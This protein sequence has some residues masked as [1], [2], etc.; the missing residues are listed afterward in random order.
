MY[1]NII[2]VWKREWNGGDMRVMPW[3]L[4]TLMAL[5]SQSSAPGHGLKAWRSK[6]SLKLGSASL[7]IGSHSWM[8]RGSY[9]WRLCPGSSTFFTCQM[10]WP[11]AFLVLPL[12]IDPRSPF[13]FSVFVFPNV[14]SLWSFSIS[15]SLFCLGDMIVLPTVIQN[16][17]IYLPQGIGDWER[18]CLCEQ[19]S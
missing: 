13:F 4:V 7:S 19:V 1:A 6:P 17:I 5:T 9:I 18:G 16:W 2:P 10:P 15:S 14:C 11:S 12:C 3:L 8:F